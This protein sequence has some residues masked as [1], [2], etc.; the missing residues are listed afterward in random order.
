MVRLNAHLCSLTNA[1]ND[2]MELEATRSLPV[3]RKCS[4]Q[5]MVKLGMPL[6]A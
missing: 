3:R 1:Q 5:A 4:T 6:A 2:P